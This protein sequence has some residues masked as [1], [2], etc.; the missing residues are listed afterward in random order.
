MY[1]MEIFEEKHLRQL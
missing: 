1:N